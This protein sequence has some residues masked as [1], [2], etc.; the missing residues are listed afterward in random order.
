[1]MLQWLILLTICAH[2]G[3]AYNLYDDIDGRWYISF[4]YL[5]MVFSQLRDRLAKAMIVFCGMS[6]QCHFLWGNA[7]HKMSKKSVHDCFREQQFSKLIAP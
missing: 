5:D 4:S 6:F 2:S 3:W 1:M 7:F